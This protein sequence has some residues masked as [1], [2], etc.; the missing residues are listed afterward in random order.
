MARRAD[1]VPKR[2]QREFRFAGPTAVSGLRLDHA[3]GAPGLRERDRS[4]EAV[5]PGPDDERVR[6]A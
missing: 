4:G 2:R 6:R 3:P 1:I 5:R